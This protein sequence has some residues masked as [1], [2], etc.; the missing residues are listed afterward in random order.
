MVV[1]SLLSLA[2]SRQIVLAT[3]GM[4]AEEECD[5]QDNFAKDH[6]HATSKGKVLYSFIRKRSQNGSH[7]YGLTTVK[8]LDNGE[9]VEVHYR[10]ALKRR[11]CSQKSYLYIYVCRCS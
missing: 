7:A 1:L 6:P 11:C 2:L 4:S 8:E 3:Q 5:G 9:R 10:T